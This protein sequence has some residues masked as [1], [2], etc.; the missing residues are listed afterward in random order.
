MRR[1]LFF[2]RTLTVANVICI[3]AIGYLKCS[4]IASEFKVAILPFRVNSDE[5]IEY[6]NR[7]IRDMLTSR[8]TYGSS[9]TVVEY[10]R[11]R[12]ALSDLPPH[13]LAEDGVQ[14]V[15]QSLEAEM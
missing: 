9:I 10:S 12:V 3:A 4:V 1:N 5:D 2:I 8:I 11:V 13:S 14:K 7:G 6:I 15:G